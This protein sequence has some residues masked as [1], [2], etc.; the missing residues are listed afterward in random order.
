MTF[1]ATGLDHVLFKIVNS[2]FRCLKLLPR[3]LGYS[4]LSFYTM[5][6]SKILNFLVHLVDEIDTRHDT[7]AND[8]GKE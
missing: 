4:G 7:N 6:T 3:P 2:G 5:S 1:A 8:A